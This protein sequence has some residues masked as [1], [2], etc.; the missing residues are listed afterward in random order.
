MNTG[1]SLLTEREAAELLS[2]SPFTLRTWRLR[3]TGPRYVR[4]GA[5]IR[6]SCVDLEA[7]IV[8]SP[9]EGRAAQ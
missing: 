4:I 8:A 7:F 3:G 5:A 6:Y 9:D 1:R 2:I